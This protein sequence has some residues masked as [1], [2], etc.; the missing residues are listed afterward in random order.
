MVFKKE[1]EWKLRGMRIAWS[2]RTILLAE[3]R[4]RGGARGGCRYGRID[5]YRRMADEPGRPIPALKS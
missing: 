4:F 1:R 2:W 3:T 5:F